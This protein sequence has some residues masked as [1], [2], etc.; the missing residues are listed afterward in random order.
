M[1]RCLKIFFAR[2]AL[3]AGGLL[4][5][6]GVANGQLTDKTQ[7]TPSVPGGAIAKSL[8]Q[9][10]GTGQGDLITPGS[11][12]YIIARDPARAIR[13][14][15]QLFQRKFTF[16]QGAGPRVNDDS[17]GNIQDN[18]A[19]GAGLVDSCAGCHGRPRGSAGVRGRRLH[20]SG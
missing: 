4:L 3:L 13:R 6:A 17:T 8:E 16:N 5:L 18:P 10:I 2:G 19:L 9:Q 11:S 14:G 7:T 12:S 1:N 15:R 20:P